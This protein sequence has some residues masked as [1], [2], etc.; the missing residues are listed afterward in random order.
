MKVF[1]ILLSGL[2]LSSGLQLQ[3]APNKATKPSP[4][5]LAPFSTAA[6]LKSNFTCYGGPF[7]SYDTWLAYVSRNPKFNAAAFEQRFP[8]KVIEQRQQQ[9]DCRIFVYE[10]DGL[11]VEGVMLQPRAVSPGKLPVV[12]YNRGGNAELGTWNYPAI[13]AFL[14]PLAEQNYIVIASQYRGAASLPTGVKPRPL[15]DQFGGD[16]VNDIKN[17][18]PIIDGMANADNQRLAMKGASRGGM[19]S[20]L[21][22]RDMPQLKALIVEAGVADLAS[23]IPKRPDMEKNVYSR[24]MP[25]YATEKPRLLKARSVL[26]WLDEL[27]PQLPIL[28]VH[29]DKD[30][31]V[32]VSQSQTLAKA[33][34]EKGHPHKLVIYPG[35]DHGMQPNRAE[36][37][38][39]TAAWLKQ[40]L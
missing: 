37:D 9:I 5:L 2:L 40:Y 34:A 19:M 16:D 11:L 24:Y 4:E 36:A 33:L 30:W 17:L 39:E 7:V 26:H 31:R 28:L 22:A 20:Y 18:L 13:Q 3:A 38:A 1:L 35:A 8:R 27:P 14:M 6:T 23:Q 32:D 10:S 29:G 15:A 25:N 21:A 12:I